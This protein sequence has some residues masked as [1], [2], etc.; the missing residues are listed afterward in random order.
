MG[1]LNPTTPTNVHIP[2]PTL[3]CPRPQ[4]SIFPFVDDAASRT[5]EG[6]QQYI[7]LYIGF[8][9]FGTAGATKE[10]AGKGI[11]HGFID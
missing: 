6:S 4:A 1:L 8:A 7:L 9:N 11:A 10:A 5:R 2:S 3:P